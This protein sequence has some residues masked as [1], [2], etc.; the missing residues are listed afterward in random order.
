LPSQDFL[1]LAKAVALVRERY[2]CSEDEAKN[3]LLDAGLNGRLEAFGSIPLSAHP[4]LN[5]AARHPARKRVALTPD[6]WASGID[7]NEERVARCFSVSIKRGSLDALL[8][9]STTA[10]TAESKSPSETARKGPKPTIVNKIKEMM[11]TDLRGGRLTVQQLR[12]MKETALEAQ[13]KASRDTC[14]RARTVV[15]SESEFVDNSPDRNS[16]K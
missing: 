9:I 8:K 11:R 3:A 16:D 13:Y 10:K 12:E 5:F 1:S 2:D 6:D 4:N 14:R 7:W 15:L